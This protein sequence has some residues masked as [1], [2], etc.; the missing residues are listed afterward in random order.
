M[1]ASRL[2]ALRV[3]IVDEKKS[4]RQ[5][6][7]DLLQAD[8]PPHSIREAADGEEAL[9]MIQ[10]YQPDLVLLDTR[11]PRLNGMQVV[12]TIGAHAMPMI[13][14]ITACDQ[15]AVRAFEAHAL[16]YVLKPFSDE[17]F[18]SMMRRVK[19]RHANLNLREAIAD[20]ATLIGH[21]KPSC[22]YL[23]RFAIKA[24]ETIRFLLVENIAWIEAAGVYVTIHAG[25][26]KALYR[27]SLTE[28]EQRLDPRRFLRVH[29]SVIVNIDRVRQMRVKSHGELEA[30]LDDGSKLPVS[31]TYRAAIETRLGQRL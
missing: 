15:D 30:I 20:I 25:A 27:I 9:R 2:Q 8:A 11:I 16:D 19:D 4:A 21:A 7:R 10:Q 22:H 14:F 18:H 13:V 24:K 26:E 3:L 23:D 28:L 31:R 29:R 17:R 1:T 12:E 6:I 5:R